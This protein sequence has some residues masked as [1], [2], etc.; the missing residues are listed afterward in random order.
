MNLDE[1]KRELRGLLRRAGV[2]GYR[3]AAVVV[4]GRTDGPDEVIVVQGRV[5]APAPR[6]KATSRGTRRERA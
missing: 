6:P 4:H 5:R 1:F 2:R 3:Y